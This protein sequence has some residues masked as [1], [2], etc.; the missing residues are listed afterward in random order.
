[1]PL[2]FGEYSGVY[3]R[4]T[5]V[6]YSGVRAADVCRMATQSAQILSLSY[7]LAQSRY[8][9][10]SCGR[11]DDYDAPCRWQTGVLHQSMPSE[12]YMQRLEVEQEAQGPHKGRSHF[13]VQRTP[14]QQA[15]RHGALG[16]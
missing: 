11:N 10:R 7:N 6:E 2:T 3:I 9:Q 5:F 14:L 16:D 15:R 8:G 13:K 4:L 1:M 12:P